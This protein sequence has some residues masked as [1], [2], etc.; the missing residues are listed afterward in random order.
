MKA[1][2]CGAVAVIALASSA[3]TAQDK[4]TLR[5][6]NVFDGPTSEKWEPVL[7]D[8]MAANPNIEVKA[9]SVA[10]SGAAVYPDVLRT[11]MASGD[12]PDVFFLWGGSIAKPFINAG[13]VEPLDAI[14]AEKGWTDRF[15]AWTVDRL[16]QD[17]KQYGVPFHGQGMNC[18]LDG[19]SCI[20]APVLRYL[21][22]VISGN[23]RLEILCVHPG[24]QGRPIIP[25]DR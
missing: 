12:P 7:A 22:P 25:L 17:G 5:F 15:P 2:L 21:C 20:R 18:D 11:S 14:F 23:R 13:Q 6:A 16:K 8:F 9:E 24:Q 10:G 19:C 1:L 3:V 4:V